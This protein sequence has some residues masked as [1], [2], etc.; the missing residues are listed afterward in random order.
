MK[1]VDM[2]D[3]I[4]VF[5]KIKKPGSLRASA[6]IDYSYMEL[7]ETSNQRYNLNSEVLLFYV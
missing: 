6:E 4:R 3:K 5:K 2:S 7:K 1:S